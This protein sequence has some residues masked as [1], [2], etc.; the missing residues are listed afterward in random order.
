MSTSALLAAASGGG[1]VEGMRV[2]LGW[3]PAVVFPAASAVQLI[4]M[5]RGRTAAGV[6]RITWSMFAVANVCLFLY[7]ENRFEVQAIATTLGTAAIQVAIVV[8]A[9]RWRTREPLGD[10]PA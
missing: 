7:I 4:V 5:L 9:T 1:G 3:V 10:A 2:A 8:L 6:S